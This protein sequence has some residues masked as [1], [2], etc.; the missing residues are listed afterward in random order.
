MCAPGTVLRAP[1]GDPLAAPPPAAPLPAFAELL[2]RSPPRR[3]V[4]LT[5]PLSAD[6]PTFDGQPHVTIVPV[7]RYAAGGFFGNRVRY[8]EHVGTHLD[9]PVHVAPGGLTVDV[10]AVEDLVLPAAVIDVRAKVAAD[11]DA[12][13]T[14]DD[15]LRFE[16]RHGR[17]PPGCAVLMWSGWDA[18]AGNAERYRN[19]D[20][21]GKMRFPGFHPEAAMMLREE[22]G[23]RGLGVDSLSLDH[24]SSTDFGAHHAILP[25]GRWGLENLT[26]LGELPALGAL[27]FVGAP[28]LRGGSGGPTRALALVP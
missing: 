22:R 16:D 10:I 8:H 24:G 13:L 19:V 21:E 11:P 9:A 12:T 23:V 2:R 6:F 7:D 15:L 18:R 25:A 3:V 5:H 14:P 4:D 1:A 27:L 17:I 28:K 20:A 26:R